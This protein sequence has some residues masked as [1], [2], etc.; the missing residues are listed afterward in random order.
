MLLITVLVKVLSHHTFKY[1]Y[2]LMDL[3]LLTSSLIRVIYIHTLMVRHL[4]F[5]GPLMYQRR[6]Y[7]HQVRHCSL[8]L[9]VHSSDDQEMA[10]A[11]GTSVRRERG[12]DIANH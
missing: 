9:H 1:Q 5:H 2:N 6:I 11:G 8:Y 10:T 7:H 4:L 3:M 12:N